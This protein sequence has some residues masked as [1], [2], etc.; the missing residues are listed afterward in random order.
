MDLLWTPDLL[1]LNTQDMYPALK[2]A[3]LL[4]VHHT[5]QV[6]AQS[7]GVVTSGC[8]MDLTHYPYDTQV[9]GIIMIIVIDCT[10]T[11]L[12]SVSSPSSNLIHIGFSTRW[13]RVALLIM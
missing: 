7:P 9:G 8:A 11:T 2:N 3:R 10:F 6:T 12:D 5:G 4:R 1:V 13:A